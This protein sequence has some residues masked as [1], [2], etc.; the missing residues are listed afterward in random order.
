[1]SLAC[2][3]VDLNLWTGA[4]AEQKLNVR[5]KQAEHEIFYEQFS[6]TQ[7]LALRLFLPASKEP[8]VVA[9]G[10]TIQAA[11]TVSPLPHIT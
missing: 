3:P 11:I 6:I 8:Y 5:V 1:M 7:A 4:A 10:K 2:Y 9:L